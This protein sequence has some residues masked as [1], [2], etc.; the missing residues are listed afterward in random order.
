MSR[1]IYLD[2]MVIEKG[3]KRRRLKKYM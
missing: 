3:V 1:G 2:L